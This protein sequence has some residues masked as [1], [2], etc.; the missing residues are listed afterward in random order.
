[1]TSAKVG[2]AWP[3]RPRS[4]A[5]QLAASLLIRPP[6]EL[7]TESDLDRVHGEL[8]ALLLGAAP[9]V[10]REGDDEP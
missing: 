5:E 6:R 9:D 3:D 2:P 7:P 1:M 4:L 8:E 10:W